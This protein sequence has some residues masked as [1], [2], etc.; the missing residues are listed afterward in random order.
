MIVNIHWKKNFRFP[1][2][3][4][5]ARKVLEKCR[6]FTSTFDLLVH[7]YFIGKL[8][9]HKSKSSINLSEVDAPYRNKEIREHIINSNFY[10]SN[11]TREEY[12]NSL[13]IS[14]WSYEDFIISAI[15]F[16]L[17]TI[18]DEYLIKQKY[19]GKV[20]LFST[21]ASFISYLPILF[22]IKPYG[23]NLFVTLKKTNIFNKYPKNCL[24]GIISLLQDKDITHD[25]LVSNPNDSFF[26]KNL[27]TYEINMNY[28]RLLLEAFDL[29]IPESVIE[30]I[31]KYSYFTETIN[32]LWW[33]LEKYKNSLSLE[34]N[35][36][37]DLI[38]SNLINNQLNIQIEKINNELK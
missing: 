4:N 20:L 17:E 33:V 10:K 27:Y 36:N 31:F 3:Y 26:F 29:F 8:N 18:Y 2:T 9:L 16:C 14:S 1:F 12:F 34:K 21:L 24:D 28:I 13:E 19:E 30:I 35:P 15:Y 38:S 25:S 37:Y 11:L 32:V 5:D 22:L 6:Y 7:T 23:K